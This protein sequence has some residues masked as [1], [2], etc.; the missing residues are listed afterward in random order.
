MSGSHLAGGHHL[1]ARLSASRRDTPPAG[2]SPGTI[3]FYMSSEQRCGSG[4][5]CL[6]DFWIRDPGWVKNQHPDPG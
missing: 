3:L 6:F 4:I 1:S 5:R 2:K